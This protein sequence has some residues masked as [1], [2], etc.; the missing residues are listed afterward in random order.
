MAID[1]KK[2]ID[3]NKRF[4]NFRYWHNIS[5]YIDNYWLED[6]YNSSYFTSKSK[7]TNHYALPTTS[8]VLKLI[9]LNNSLVLSIKHHWF[10]S[11]LY[12]KLIS[13]FNDLQFPAKF[14]NWYNSKHYT[15]STIAWQFHFWLK[16]V[17]WKFNNRKP[18]RSI[19]KWSNL[20][21]FRRISSELN[22]IRCSR[23]ICKCS[24]Q[25][26]LETLLQCSIFRVNL[27]T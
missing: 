24:S 10:Y 5:S 16:L 8:G 6:I 20:G 27:C 7:I 9:F 21:I 1:K 18:F 23:C 19:T 2:N 3:A 22:I 4:E 11:K 26:I 14:V 25:C 12:S 15:S 13:K 17:N